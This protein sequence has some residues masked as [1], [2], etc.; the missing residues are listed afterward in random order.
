MKIPH[1]KF[2]TR[3]SISKVAIAIVV[4]VIII[5]VGF[6]SLYIFDPAM[7]GLG[8]TSG[9]NCIVTK[10]GS[11]SSIV[12]GATLSESGNLQAFGQEQNWTL[13]YVVNYVNSIGGIP[14]S[15]G[16]HVN[17][18]LV[19]LDDASDPATASTN[20]KT[21]VTQDNACII[22][23]ELGGV[24]D[25]TAQSFASQYSIPYIGPVYISQ[26]KTCT[27]NCSSS[28]IFAPFQNE[29]NEAHIFLNWFSKEDPSSSSNPVTIAFFGEGDPAAVFNNMA[30]EAYAKQLGYTVC[31]CSDLSF[32]PGST[33]EMGNFISAA[34]SAGA[35]AVY[36]LPL[37]NDAVLMLNTAQQQGYVPKAWLLTR[38]TAVAPF[39][40]SALGG[41]GNVSSGV[42]SSFPW[43]PLVTYTG[44]ILGH[45]VSNPKIVSDYEAVWGHPPTL[46]GVYYTEVLVAVDAIQTAGTLNNIA[47]RNA[48]LSSTFS[49][50]M[51]TVNFTPG[52]QWVQSQQYI[53]LMQWQN[54]V[55]GGRTIQALQIL[56]PTNENTTN[57]L[58]Y[59]FSF[60]NAQNSANQTKVSWP[61]PGM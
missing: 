24:Q 56:E 17:I 11:S 1:N 25:S 42:M 14:L 10:S 61:Q 22:L 18:S 47:I 57:Y 27:T 58:I 5:A 36:G 54:I 49:T 23:G 20:L 33:S 8:G 3:R 13:H 9:R 12:F 21:L 26:Y 59:P 41:L 4:V 38:G 32:T 16:Q 31:T 28:W 46:E 2:G 53:L 6:A 30:G 52:G 34:K 37:P 48:L 40:V 44:I 7:F 43:D 19:V 15:N 35:Q 51:G 50:P 55:V 39:A 60:Q 45:S 29:T